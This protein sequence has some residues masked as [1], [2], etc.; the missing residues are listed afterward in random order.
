[1]QSSKQGLWTGYHLSI[2]GLPK[3]YLFRE[4]IV[5]K[6][7]KG[8]T[9]ERSLPALTF[10]ASPPPLPQVPA[11]FRFTDVAEFMIDITY[12]I[13]VENVAIGHVDFGAEEGHW[14]LFEAKTLKLEVTKC[15][16]AKNYKSRQTNKDMDYNNSSRWF[17]PLGSRDDADLKKAGRVASQILLWKSNI[18]RYDHL[19]NSP[20]VWWQLTNS[21][22]FL[23]LTT[24]ICLGF[25]W[26]LTK[27]LIVP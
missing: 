24:D 19:S 8:W 23:K 26:Q 21:L 10:V 4:K 14:R 11:F 25:Y 3:E 18:R 15:E 16:I 13:A 17:R 6:R 5:Y 2:E 7:V 9:L 20:V 22:K 12:Y 27:D 1:M